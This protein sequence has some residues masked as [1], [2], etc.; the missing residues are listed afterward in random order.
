[1]S[2]YW[3]LFASLSVVGSL[4]Y[5]VGMKL[6][7][8]SMNAFGFAFLMN[9]VVLS[10][11]TVFCLTAKYVFKADVMQ[12]VNVNTLKF[13]LLT[14]LGAALVDVSY[15]SALRYGSVISSQIFWTVGGIV[16]VTA[17]AALF[18]GETLSATKALGIALGVVAVFLI[19]K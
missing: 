13:A 5:T 16:A 3:L 11:Q 2:L 14:G 1:M 17:F 18:L 12:G 8:P 15:F 7:S 19:T 6:G 10:S 4:A 9:I